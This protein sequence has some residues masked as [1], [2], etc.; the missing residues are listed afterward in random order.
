[1]V[2]R[3]TLLDL[4][5]G[6]VDLSD[7]SLASLSCDAEYDAWSGDGGGRTADMDDVD[8]CRLKPSP[9]PVSRSKESLLACEPLL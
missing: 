4:A 1:M 7:D 8:V 3:M 9:G 5:I 2:T 6:G